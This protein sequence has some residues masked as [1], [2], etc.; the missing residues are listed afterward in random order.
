MSKFTLPQ[1]FMLPYGICTL[2]N[3]Y[4]FDQIIA[5]LNSIEAIMGAD[6]PVCI[7][8][9]D[10]RIDRLAEAI[11]DRP[12]VQIY[13]AAESIAYWD[14]QAQRIWDIH[15]TAAATWAKV[16]TDKYH[17]MG[18]H[19]RF[20]AFDGP[21]ERFIYM[22]ADTL[23]MGDVQPIFNQLDHCDWYVYDFQHADI[24]HVYNHQVPQLNAVFSPDRLAREIFCSGFY[25]SK[26]GVFGPEKLDEMWQLLAAGEAE[27]LYSMAPDQTIL[28][29]WVMRSEI[30]SYNAALELSPE[31]TTGCCV[32]SDH[33]EVRDQIVYDRGNR[34]TY[35]HYIGLPSGLFRE[36]CAGQN[37]SCAYR[38]VFLH[39]RY[40]REPEAR[41]QFSG[42]P[43]VPPPKVSR[44]RQLFNQLKRRTA[45]VFRPA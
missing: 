31:K 18:T 13:Q 32:T 34:L 15:P 19:R 23:L 4:V 28:N 38:D 27:I 33:F 26:R 8:P 21:F 2:G 6:F 14:R 11:Q 16:T 40:L 24:T 9:Y 1:K 45:K 7:Y 5:L 42:S 20:C 36:I 35:L 22:D 10:D 3:D 43:Q 30:K 41:P 44:R 12:N 37:W 39:Y 29:Y 17:R 25:A